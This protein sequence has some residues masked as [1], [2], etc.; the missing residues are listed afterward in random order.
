[1]ETLNNK[2]TLSPRRDFDILFCA[3][4]GLGEVGKNMY[5]FEI[6]EKIFIMDSGMSFSDDSFLGVNYIIPSY[7]YLIKNEHKIVCLLITHGHE[8]HIGSIPYLLKR[9]KIPRIFV[10]GIAYDLIEFKLT[11][12]KLHKYFSIIEKYFYDSELVFDDVKISFVRLNH[13]IP[14]TFGVVFRY[15]QNILFYTGDFKIDH[16]PEGPLAEY[17]KLSDL[18]K[19]GVLCLLSDST[20]AQQQGLIES[21]YKIGST[22]NKLFYKIKNRIII[23]TFASNFYR[24]KQ[25]IEASVRT[26]RKVAVFGRSMEKA[27]DT[28][29]KNGYLKVP[30][31]FLVNGNNI[32]KYDDITLLCTGSQGEP[33]A[34]LSR[35]AHGIHRQIKL[36]SKDTVIFSSS[37]IP[38]NQDSVNKILDLLYKMDVNV[39]I[40][41]FLVD[42]HASGHASQNDLKLM[43]NLV[44]PK[45]F[46]PVHGEYVMLMAHKKLAIEC[47]LLPENIFVLDNGD[48]LGISR[49]KTQ[50]IGKI[51]YDNIY[52]DDS[53]MEDLGSIILKERKILNEEGL[54]SII[55]SIDTKKKKIVNYPMIV[56]RGF[57]Y[58][59][60][61][62]ELITQISSDVKKM[63]QK[64]LRSDTI[65]KS[66][67]KKVI[68]DFIT[69]QIYESTLRNPL[70]LPIILTI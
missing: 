69:P 5:I 1:M 56:S 21:E 55:V 32:D 8:D 41:G 16:T 7:D 67:L 23:V 37:P 33:L 57:I 39:I 35:M 28:G 30:K 49:N 46:I 64:L 18:G 66:Y 3:L 19:E 9:V 34:A 65:N 10:S 25:I 52:I 47:G 43:L 59:K 36:N 48:L 22:I 68:V 51:P 42:T 24:I 17:S 50:L 45:Y 15:H 60:G 58:M 63:L 70:I 20:N 61:N 13:S 31:E 38:G 14:D 6:K 53:G 40:H 62:Q 27:I 2:I 54:L 11:E 44:K 26:N 4:G 12:H 29:L